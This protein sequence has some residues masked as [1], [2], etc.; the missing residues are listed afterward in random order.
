MGLYSMGFARV[1]GFIFHVTPYKL[2]AF[3]SRVLMVTS[4]VTMIVGIKLRQFLPLD[5]L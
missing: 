4:M 1:G 2:N 3:V 5:S